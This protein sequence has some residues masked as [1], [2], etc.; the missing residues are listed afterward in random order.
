L[1]EEFK[2][3]KLCNPFRITTLIIIVSV[4]IV[5]KEEED[6]LEWMPIR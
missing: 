2:E 5:K 6:Q 3:L 1:G 4:R